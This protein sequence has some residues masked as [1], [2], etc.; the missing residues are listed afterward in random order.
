MFVELV[1]VLFRLEICVVVSSGM[2]A[3]ALVSV[4]FVRAI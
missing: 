4:V 1:S 3:D 2:F